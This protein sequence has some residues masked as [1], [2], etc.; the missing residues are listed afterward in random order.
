MRFR[1]DRGGRP[2]RM[3]GMGRRGLS[4]DEDRQ[5]GRKAWERSDWTVALILLVIMAGALVFRLPA[6]GARPMHGDEA[7]QAT[8]AAI[9]LETGRYRYDPHE[10]H[11]PTLYYLTL[12][13]MW[14]T[15]VKSFVDS[16][17][18]T[19]RIVP[20]FFGIGLIAWLW[21]VRK[22]LG[23]TPTLLAA[24][25]TA[26][27]PAMVFYSRYY[28]QEML[29]VFFTF[30][31]IAA[32]WRYWT[33]RRLGWAAA[34]GAALAL[35]HAT[36]ETAVFAFAAMAG[37]LVLT[38]WRTKFAE[39]RRRVTPRNQ[40]G[41]VSDFIAPASC[42]HS[43]IEDSPLGGGATEA[44]TPP[45]EFGDGTRSG[46]IL[47]PGAVAT[48]VGAA[49]IVWLVFYSSF[50]MHPRGL[51]DSVLTYTSYLKRAGGA[52]MH[53]HPWYYYL[54]LLTYSKA[55]LGPRWSEGLILVL[56]I[57]GFAAAVVPKASPVGDIRLLRFLAF[58][59]VL[60]TAIYALVPYKTPWCVLTF[61][62]GMILLAGVG[63]ISLIR[64]A[65]FLPLRVVVAALLAVGAYQ[66]GT[67]AYRASY[68]Y[69]SDW[70]NPYVYAHPA[71]D[72]LRL[73]E[74]AEDL[75][76]VAPE[77][78]GLLV[79]VISAGGDYWPL[80]WYLRRFTHVGYYD[81]V[82]DNPDAEFIIVA[83]DL[84]PQLDPK[85]RDK[86]QVEFFGLRPNVM[87][88]VYTRSDIWDAFMKGRQ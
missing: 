2:F 77:G 66:L 88:L 50:F 31:A 76:K 67:Q 57:V 82:P 86:Y 83:R 62:H 26:V 24:V 19:Y 72:V 34:T 42:R 54:K 45:D 48:F 15:G 25:M 8:K 20:V 6:L 13:V 43:R 84:A 46:S 38:A 40:F 37:A 44:R 60:L 59:T 71:G 51:I 9:L 23:R 28:I 32:G 16:R 85:L 63:A 35:M 33:T 70:R 21:W 52:G 64:W 7:N 73:A 58:Y 75:A 53:D 39:S 27:S 4:V 36:K 68:V 5:S 17:E 78:H 18:T 47:M 1:G 10:H 12:P 11:G 49:L 30:A 61:L 3:S 87:L 81:Q 69:A 29:L 74:R 80:P 65:R 55:P 22:G 41:D 56:A 79:R 14:L